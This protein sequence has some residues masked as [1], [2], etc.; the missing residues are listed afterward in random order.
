MHEAMLWKVE[1]DRVHCH[2]CPHSCRIADG[3]RGVCGVRENHGGKLYAMTYG[4]VSSIAVDP[5]EKKPVYHYFPGTKALSLGSVGCTMRCEHCQNWQISRSKPGE[6]DGVADNLNC[7]DPQTVIDVAERYGCLGVAFT[8]NEPVIWIEYVY[9]VARLCQEAG[10][11][12]VMVTNGFIT[13]EGLDL[14][15]RHIDVWRVDVK[16][17]SDETMKGLCKVPS[18][19]P[20]LAQA[21]RAKKHW[22]MHV[23]V[24][25]NVIPTINDDEEQIRS[26]ARWIRDRLGPETPWHVTRFFPYLELSHLPPTPIPTLRR[27]R[28]I[29]IEEGLEFV[30]LGN[31]AGEP[32]GE[33]TRCPGCG[34]VVIGRDGYRVVT[35]H[36]RDGACAKCGRKLGVVS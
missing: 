26:I 30:Y 25:T 35:Q 4:E 8:Y 15:G 23:E 11:Y 7:V 13:E 27:A 12:T 22:Q 16:G 20:I 21:E 19:E 1:G 6:E 17:F 2:L 32:G 29:G 28:E 31:V 33:D 9:D 24:V 14:V 18:V 34:Q 3:R 5:I 10:L 36:L